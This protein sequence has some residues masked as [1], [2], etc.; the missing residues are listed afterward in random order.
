MGKGVGGQRQEGRSAPE[1]AASRAGPRETAAPGNG[2]GKG[3]RG[4]GSG[5][6]GLHRT[7]RVR[8]GNGACTLHHPPFGKSQN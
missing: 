3:V 5:P 8:A 4:L 2:W 6:S 1:R 7:Q